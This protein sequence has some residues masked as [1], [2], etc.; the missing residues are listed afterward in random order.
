[1]VTVIMVIITIV[2]VVMV[3]I[4]CVSVNVETTTRTGGEEKG[5]DGGK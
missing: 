4:H 3:I 2:T 1:M 5:P